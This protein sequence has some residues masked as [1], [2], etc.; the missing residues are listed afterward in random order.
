LS[1]NSDSLHR[2]RRG[3]TEWRFKRV[4][5]ANQLDSL[6]NLLDFT[7]EIKP[8]SSSFSETPIRYKVK[9]VSLSLLVIK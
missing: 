5:H 7:L 4:E 9:L 8:K 2:Q 1:A 3:I 6:Y